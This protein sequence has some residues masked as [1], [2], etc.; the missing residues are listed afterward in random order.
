MKLTGLWVVSLRSFM[1]SLLSW[2]ESYFPYQLVFGGSNSIG[3][4]SM[5]PLMRTGRRVSKWE[6]M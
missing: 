3:M 4:L 6:V 2:A 1:G 5:S